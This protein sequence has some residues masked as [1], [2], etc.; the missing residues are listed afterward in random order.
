VNLQPVECELGENDTPMTY[1]LAALILLTFPIFVGALKTYPRRRTWAFVAI[2]LLPMLSNLPLV[3]FIYG[4]PSWSGTVRGFGVSVLVMLSLA[5]IATRPNTPGKLPFGGLFALYG[6]ALVS[7]IFAAGAWLAT[8]FVWWQFLS[9]LIVFAAVGKESHNPAVFSKILTGFALG[10]VFQAAHSIPQKLTGATQAG[11]TF[12]HQN[13]LGLAVEL[14]LLP[15]I[16]AMLAGDRRKVVIIGIVS[17][18]VTVA[19]SGS[20]ATLGIT[21]GGIVLLT[22]LSLARRPTSRKFN[23]VLVGAIMLGAVTPLALGT[24]NDRFRGASFLVGDDERVRFEQSARS[25]ANSHPFGVGANH[26]VFVSN[27]D[28]YADR[29]GIS[30]QMSDRSVP[31]HNAYLLA[32]AETGWLGELAFILI[33]AVPMI[34]AF[35]LA[36]RDRKFSGGDVL[37]GCGIALLANMAHNTYEFAVHTFS[38]QALLFVNLGMVAAQLRNRAMEIRLARLHRMRDM[39]T[40]ENP[41]RTP[42]LGATR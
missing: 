19:L 4:W 7:S 30:W 42:V 34:A 33:L 15:L 37:L 28:G 36:F 17:G 22:L 10:L 23:I 14:S 13:I 20:R 40:E 1:V 18:L 5:L 11:G 12:G 8:V 16:A 27:R 21:G 3:G 29:Y 6:L 32:R 35:R 26:F 39:A 41:S 9:M 2:G 24:L 38:I 31:V 25:M